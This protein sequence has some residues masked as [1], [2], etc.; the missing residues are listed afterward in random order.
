MEPF[1]AACAGAWM[2]GAAAR[3]YGSGLI[4]EDLIATLPLVW[5]ELAGTVERPEWTKS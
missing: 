2:H 1:L 4:A 5:S 3:R